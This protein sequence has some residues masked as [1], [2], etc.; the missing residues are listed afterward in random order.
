MPTS[1]FGGTY[2]GDEVE[3]GPRSRFGGQYV[4]SE[5][6]QY[7]IAIPGMPPGGAE[8]ERAQSLEQLT[9]GFLN[10]GAFEAGLGTLGSVLG[11]GAGVAGSIPSFGLGAPVA[12]PAGM[13]AGSALGTGAGSLLYDAINS[14]VKMFQDPDES[15]SDMF[16]PLKRAGGA[17]AVDLAFTG[18]LTALQPL[19]QAGRRAIPGLLGVKDK[20]PLERMARDKGINL[21]VIQATDFKGVKAASR[22]A[23]VFPFIGR[24][25]QKLGERAGQE[26][27][28]AWDRAL[29]EIAPNALVSETGV[30]LVKAAKEGFKTFRRT[31]G[32]LYDR[33]DELANLATDP[34][35][36]NTASI[37]TP[38]Y[39]IIALSRDADIPLKQ[40]GPETTNLRFREERTNIGKDAMGRVVQKTQQPAKGGISPD[41]IE[42]LA[43]DTDARRLFLTEE[44]S[45]FDKN[46][47]AQIAERLS[48]LP[49]KITVK[50][51]RG[52]QRELR[53][54]METAVAQGNNTAVKD[55]MEIKKGLERAIHNP[56]VDKLPPGE[57]KSITDALTAAN[58]FYA[59]GIGRYQTATAK[60]FGRVD[61]KAFASGAFKA[62]TLNA[63]EAFKAVFNAK[64]P[65]AVNDLRQ[66]VSPDAF[67]GATRQHLDQ[68]FKGAWQPESVGTARATPF[69]ADVFRKN[70][71]LDSPEGRKT[72]GEMLKFSG[73]TVRDLENFATAAHK[74]GDFGIPDPSVFLQRRITLGGLR[75]ILG[76]VA[77]GAGAATSPVKVAVGIL[78]VNKGGQ[79][80]T[81]PEPLRN[82]IRAVEMSRDPTQTP[83]VKAM[84]LRIAR[85][86]G[87]EED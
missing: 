42:R 40:A 79:I 26:T 23:G 32:T 71:G 52:L 68:A 76:G 4:E 50:Q 18:G 49:E 28:A 36:I 8:L 13:A 45:I 63:D 82:M 64:S 83:Q 29:D 48:R 57:A 41:D 37:K 60:K 54:A 20:G 84:L 80:L 30:D 87:V 56:A 24:P 74:A 53:R 70:V 22:V 31:A 85:N 72:L 25:Y 59:E 47:Q 75:N 65:E 14:V 15:E 11:A 19:F 55:Y 35:I 61:K 10:R 81:K 3:E 17:G 33:Y 44:Q 86:I 2:V 1:K 27:Q 46:V 69:N 51:A 66:I 67:K 77:M 73:V 62:G 16:G 78:L 6:P 58:Q 12:V 43:G 34:N 7:P 39:R 9:G 38:A 21:G 5:T